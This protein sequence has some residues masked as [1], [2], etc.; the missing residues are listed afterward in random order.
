[1]KKKAGYHTLKNTYK[2]T[3]KK[4]IIGKMIYVKKYF[5]QW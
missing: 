5:L 4:D 1:M 2:N 3:L